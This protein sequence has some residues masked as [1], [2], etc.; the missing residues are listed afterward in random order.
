MPM[1]R[2]AQVIPDEVQTFHCISQCVRQSPLLWSDIDDRKS[3][4][5]QRLIELARSLA[6]D[7]IA[8][9]LMDTH[10]HT[11][12]TTRPDLAREFSA[13]EVAR[14]WFGIYPE[15]IHRWSRENLIAQPDLYER[16]HAITRRLSD[17]DAIEAVS[18]QAERI[19]E[20]RP[21]LSS[22]SEFHQIIKQEVARRANKYDGKRG[23]FWDERYKS[24]QLLDDAARVL[25][26]VYIDLNPVRAAVFQRPEDAQYTSAHDRILVR[27]YLAG[28]LEFYDT[29]EDAA[30]ATQRAKKKAA[31]RTA[32]KNSRRKLKRRHEVMAQ[33]SITLTRTE[34]EQVMMY[35][36]STTERDPDRAVW[37]APVLE[38]LGIELDHYL[39]LLD[40]IGRIVRTDKRG[41]IP[42]HLPPILERIGLKLEDLVSIAKYGGALRG[43]VIGSPEARAEVARRRG[44]TRVQNAFG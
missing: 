17:D 36:R 35:L 15:S 40:T 5:H 6:I 28:D 20:L 23:H 8:V 16:R 14:R 37:L 31:R 24:I 32:K 44:V 4:F 12:L 43:T 19:A 13:H 25:V 38:S 1:P 27:R 33:S 10:F 18:R 39:Q 41:S 2:S 9:S 3:W 42:E 30:R 7:L 26:A 29:P 22:M 34:R 11:E 21:R